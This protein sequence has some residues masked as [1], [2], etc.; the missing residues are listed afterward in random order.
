[1]IQLED[2]RTAAARLEGVA[3][4]TPVLRSTTLDTWTGGELLLKAE[5]L[6][7]MG[8]FKFR[9]AYNAV[10][11]LDDAARARGVCAY[12][13][14]NHAQ[15][16]AL[17]ARLHGTRATIVMPADTPAVKLEA[18]RGYGAEVVLYD[19]YT[20]DRAQVGRRLAD[21][22]GM[23]LIPPFDHAD[24]MAGQGTAAL[25]L[26][27]DT[28]D[29]GPLDV[30]VV[31]VGGGGL[32]SGCATAAK[33]LSP[34][35]RVVGVEPA[36]RDVA[37]RSLATGELVVAPVPTTIADGQQGDRLGALTL[38]VMRERVDEVVA[39]TDDE[40]RAAMRVLFDRLKQVVEPSGASALAAVLAGAIDVRGKRVG[41]TLSGG[42]VGLERFVALMADAPH[43]RV[44]PQAPPTR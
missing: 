24:V 3:I 14:G 12:S 1:M 23:T 36:A 10:S 31:C 5:H 20:E 30:L 13:S 42:N 2:V 6:Q 4:R 37:R 33:A 18:T 44:S 41:I 26:I 21:E 17:S 15:A 16:V 43:P 35:T 11:A 27:E 32:I 8:A 34:T 25:E 7:R 39:V 40:I 9:G 19:R 28:A 29:G 22:R 38:A